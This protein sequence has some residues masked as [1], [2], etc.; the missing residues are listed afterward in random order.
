MKTDK[1]IHLSPAPPSLHCTNCV[2]KIAPVIFCNT[3]FGL[4]TVFGLARP[5]IQLRP[6]PANLATIAKLDEIIKIGGCTQLR[7]V[8]SENKHGL[9]PSCVLLRVLVCELLYSN[10]AAFGYVGAFYSFVP[11][12]SEITQ[13]EFTV[14]TPRGNLRQNHLAINL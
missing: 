12:L 14:V 4:S 6:R 11:H 1:N 10:L 8:G 5:I 9:S 3:V 7:V 2:Q 13:K